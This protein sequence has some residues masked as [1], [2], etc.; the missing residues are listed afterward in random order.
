MTKPCRDSKGRFVS[1]G[2]KK[3]RLEFLLSLLI[4]LSWKVE[5]RLGFYE[6]FGGWNYMNSQGIARDLRQFRIRYGIYECF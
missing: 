1:R 4:P 6:I 3:R 2:E 5:H